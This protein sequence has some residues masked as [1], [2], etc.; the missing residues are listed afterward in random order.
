MPVI[1]MAVGQPSDPAPHGGSRGR[2]ARRLKDGR[3]GYTDALGLRGLREAIAAHYARALRRRRSAERIAVTT[4]SSAAFNLAFLAMF[5]AGD[6]VAI[7][8]PGYPAY[9]N[10]L[11]ALGIEVVEIELDG[12]GLPAL[13]RTWRPRMPK[14][15]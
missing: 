11:A 3:I 8:A 10:I 12:A 2:G 9:R 14:S 15:R 6:R 4:G 1:S 13:P 7:A 5:D